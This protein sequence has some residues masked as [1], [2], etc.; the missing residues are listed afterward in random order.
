MIAATG[1]NVYVLWRYTNPE[2]NHEVFFSASIDSG[3]TFSNINLSN[4]KGETGQTKPAIAAKDDKV[5]VVWSEYAPY[6]QDIMYL[7]GTA[8]QSG[9]D[10]QPSPEEAVVSGSILPLYLFISIGAIAGVGVAAFAISRRR[11]TD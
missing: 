1:N 9:T 3:K 6:T 5:H 10:E 8:S 4:D 11:K 7:G 2:G